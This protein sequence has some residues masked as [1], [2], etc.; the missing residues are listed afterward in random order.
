MGRLGGLA[1]RVAALSESGLEAAMKG[2]SKRL[3]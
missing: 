3:V 1:F 2:K